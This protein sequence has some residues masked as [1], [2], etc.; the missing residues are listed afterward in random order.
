MKPINGHSS[1]SGLLEQMR[2]STSRPWDLA[3]TWAVEL[4]KHVD[5]LDRKATRIELTLDAIEPVLERL[6]KCERQAMAQDIALDHKLSRI[7][8]QLQQ[9]LDAQ[10]DLLNKPSTQIESHETAKTPNAK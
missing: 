3:I 4:S 2:E 1:L 10:Q 5:G 6:E 7:A 8:A 9:F